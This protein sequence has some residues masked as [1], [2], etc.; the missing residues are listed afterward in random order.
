MNDF[1]RQYLSRQWCVLFSILN[2]CL[3]AKQYGIDQGSVY[4]LR[5]FHGVT[6]NRQYDYASIIWEEMKTLVAERN[7]PSKARKY[8]PF[9][10]FFTIIICRFMEQEP[11]IS[12]LRGA[13]ILKLHIMKT[14]QTATGSDIAVPM[15]IPDSLLSL[16]DP[17]HQSVIHYRD[18][19]LPMD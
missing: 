16:A 2:R 8:I 10:R 14:L 7:V 3:T 18:T 19:H 15:R 17:Q 13:P 5:I 9:S 1:K 6:F 11:S 12:R 4:I